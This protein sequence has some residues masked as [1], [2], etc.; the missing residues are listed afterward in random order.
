MC[1]CSSPAPDGW[2]DLELKFK[3]T[4]L[5]LALG[6]D[7]EEPYTEVEISVTGALPGCL[8]FDA[9]DCVTLMPR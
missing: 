4:D 1:D 2:P 7:L 3:R 6:L 9:T 5:T 8:T